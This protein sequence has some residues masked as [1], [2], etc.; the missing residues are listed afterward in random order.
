MKA[1]A[2]LQSGWEARNVTCV[3]AMRK[4]LRKFRDAWHLI[5]ELQTRCTPPKH[6]LHL[7]KTKCA[8][9]PGGIFMVA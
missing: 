1:A 7:H 9:L 8:S 2:R 5:T 6:A 4:G 3:E